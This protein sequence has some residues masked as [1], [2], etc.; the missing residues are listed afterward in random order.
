MRETKARLG[1]ECFFCSFEIYIEIMQTRKQP[2]L[3][4]LHT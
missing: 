4:L 3:E 1:K 2:M